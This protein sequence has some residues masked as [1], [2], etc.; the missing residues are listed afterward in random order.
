MKVSTIKMIWKTRD[1]MRLCI[2]DVC[3]PFACEFVLKF[4]FQSVI[5]CVVL[6]TAL[7]S[8]LTSTVVAK[9]MFVHL[10]FFYRE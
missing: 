1:N 3:S 5:C 6:V 10:Y 7:S 9:Q 2:K 4:V 8:T